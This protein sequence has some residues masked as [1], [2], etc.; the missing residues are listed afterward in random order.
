MT[1]KRF[2]KPLMIVSLVAA[3]GLL[4]AP[5]SVHT[6]WASSHERTPMRSPG[7][8]MEAPQILTM[9]RPTT[10]DRYL[11]Y[12]STRLQLEAMKV[13]QPGVAEMTLTIDK[14][15]RVVRTEVNRVDGPPELREHAI[16]I[17]E[18]VERFPPLPPDADADVLVM[19]TLLAFN[20][21]SGELMDRFG[22]RQGR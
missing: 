16:R 4:A 8:Q 6:T 10:I 9:E 22:Q 2:L 14:D 1:E 3:L 18:G 17:V 13:P 20:Y 15:G 5:L 19:T 7:A 11:D 12:V 21:P